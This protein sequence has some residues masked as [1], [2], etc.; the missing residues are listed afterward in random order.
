[1]VRI[2]YVE[3]K[4]SFGLDPQKPIESTKNVFG[5]SSPKN[6]P[7]KNVRTH[8]SIRHI[9]SSPLSHTHMYFLIFCENSET[10]Q[11]YGIWIRILMYTCVTLFGVTQNKIIPSSTIFPQ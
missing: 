5:G 8:S 9:I 2:K 3:S 10:M 6:Q 11:E 4:T 1:M 7:P